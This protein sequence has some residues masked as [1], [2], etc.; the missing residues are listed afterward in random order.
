[1]RSKLSFLALLCGGILSADQLT[2]FWVDRRIALGEQIPVITGLFELVHY[3]NPGAAF[4]LFADWHSPN[5]GYFFFAM[6]ILAA[7]FLAYY[8]FKTPLEEKRT[9]VSLGMILSGALGNL[10]DRVFRGTVVD[11]LLFHW[12]DK[13]ISFEIF[14]RFHRVELVWPAF[15]VADSAITLGVLGL[16]WA[17]FKKPKHLGS[18]V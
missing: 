16:F 8:L 12:Y 15:N 5:R 13:A 1:M 9:L 3:R 14:G 11:F 7:I 17:A 10:I 6:S 18:G 2:K 4:S